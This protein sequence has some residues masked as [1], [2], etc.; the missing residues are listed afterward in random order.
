M[1]RGDAA[2]DGRL[3]EGA[4][5]VVA[6]GE[7][8]AAAEELAAFAVAI[9]TYFAEVSIWLLLT[10][11]PTWTDSS[12]PLPIFRA[13]A[14]ATNFVGEFRGDSLLKKDAAGGGAALACGS[15]GSPERAVEGELEVGVVEDDLRVLAAHFEGDGLEGGGGTLGNVRAHFAGAG[16]ADGA[17]VGVLDE[18]VAGGAAAAAD[19]VDDARRQ[20]GIDERLHQ[21]VDRER[22][23][24]GG[25]D[26]AGV[27]ADERGKELP[28]AGWPWGSSTA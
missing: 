11:G 22:R 1:L 6:V 12:R 21:V 23:V 24:G 27:A 19:D 13:F 3:K 15:E 9:S 7:R 17:D 2:E 16:E 10:C 28:A 25:L 8:V 20:A 14:R 5:G 4:L 18:G 26:D